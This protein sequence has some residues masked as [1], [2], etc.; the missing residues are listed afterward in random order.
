MADPAGTFR[1]VNY[2][3]AQVLG[4]EPAELEGSGFLDLVH[5][6]DRPRTEEATRRAASGIPVLGFENRFLTR[7]GGSR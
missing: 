4:R 7:D 2:A 3:F 5:P 1:R 6:D